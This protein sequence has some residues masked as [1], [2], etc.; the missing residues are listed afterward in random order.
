M[1]WFD[2]TKAQDRRVANLLTGQ[3]AGRVVSEE[4]ETLTGGT[5]LPCLLGWDFGE[6]PCVGVARESPAART[7]YTAARNWH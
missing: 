2:E 7:G 5:R 3:L 4:I 6:I 1:R